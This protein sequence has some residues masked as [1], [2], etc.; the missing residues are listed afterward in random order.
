VREISPFFSQAELLHKGDDMSISTKS[1]D[2]GQTSLWSGESVCKD[3]I[4][5]EA[6]GS[7]DELNSFFGDAKHFVSE[8]AKEIIENI[9]KLLFRVMGEL[10]S[11]GKSFSNPIGYDEVE[12]LTK[13]VHS[14][15][16]DV[17]FDGFVIPGNTI[18]AAKL[19]ICRTVCRRAERRII[20]LASTE[21]VSEHII[22]FVNRLSDLLFV[23]QS[24][25]NPPLVKD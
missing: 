9:Q 23:L 10:A 6:Y 1:G 16:K 24:H 14:Y 20:S 5:V 7:L 15:E 2:K 25:L 11:R 4:R 17:R 22:A 12:Y 13:L 8:E 3:D 19:D 18:A 21:G